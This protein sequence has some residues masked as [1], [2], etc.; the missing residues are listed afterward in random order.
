[1]FKTTKNVDANFLIGQILFLIPTIFYSI[2]FHNP[3]VD[4]PTNLKNSAVLR[5]LEEESNQRN[6]IGSGK[7]IYSENADFF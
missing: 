5:M 1:M 2:N 6:G 7:N 4:K 3:V